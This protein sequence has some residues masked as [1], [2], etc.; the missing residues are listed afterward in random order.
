MACKSGFFPNKVIETDQARFLLARLY[1]DALLDKR[2]KSKV[3]STLETLSNGSQTLEKAYDDAIKRLESQLPEDTALATRVI[4]WIV[5]AERAFTITELRHALAVELVETSFDPD[6]I[7][8][9]EDIVS[10]C[11]GLVTVD[12]TSNIIRLVHYTAQEYFERVRHTW[13]PHGQLDITSTCLTY[14][15]FDVFRSGS[16]SDGAQYSSRLRAYPFFEY[17]AQ[18]W[19]RHAFSVQEEVFDMVCAALFDKGLSSSMSQILHVTGRRH[20]NYRQ[21]NPQTRDILHILSYFGLHVIA[22]KSLAQYQSSADYWVAQKDDVHKTCLYV[23]VEQ[24]HDAMVRLLLDRGAKVNEEVGSFGTVL[25]VAVSG[26]SSSMVK[27]LLDNGADVNLN[28]WRGTTAGTAL[29]LASEGDNIAMARLLLEHG[30]DA[31]IEN[32]H[33]Q[34]PIQL[35]AER[36]SYQVVKLLLDWIPEGFLGTAD[37]P[38]YTPLLWAC[39]SGQLGAVRLFLSEGA[40]A[41]SCVGQGWTSL[42]AASNRGHL[43]VVQMLLDNG[44][45]PTLRNHKGQTALQCALSKSYFLVVELLLS[46]EEDL[47]YR[48]ELARSIMDKALSKGRLATVKM[49]LEKGA[50]VNMANEYGRTLIHNAARNGQLEAVEL[51]LKHGADL[52]MADGGGFTALNHA[53]TRGDRLDIIKL[54]QEK[55]AVLSTSGRDTDTH[56]RTLLHLSARSGHIGTLLHFADQGIDPLT[57]DAKGDDLLSY[58]SSSGSLQVFKVALGMAPIL[59]VYDGHWSPLHWACRGGN[60]EYVKLLVESGLQ[61]HC[62]TLPQ[63]EAIWSPADIAIHHGHKGG[64][65]DL[66]DACKAALGPVAKPERFIG[67]YRKGWGCDGCLNVSH[68]SRYSSSTNT[69]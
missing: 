60:F 14:L 69:L 67:E 24:N 37:E 23:A 2:T 32:T 33:G 34:T 52:H 36:R 7:V 21:I 6:N 4:S 38:R 59:A 3:Q 47:D 39:A 56:N 31:T 65:R 12:K 58:A 16:C 30:A 42:H 45:D 26:G 35:A 28:N 51:L 5:Y 48:G 46:R 20:S 61:G 62:V 22:E 8:D 27:L 11:A 68:L 54:L 63:P 53:V 66:S 40:D 13:R 10:V 49:F 43:Q 64:L 18:Y 50:E 1:V 19:G 29:H 55:G 41:N 9:I 17:A 44:A 57:K 25:K 15:S